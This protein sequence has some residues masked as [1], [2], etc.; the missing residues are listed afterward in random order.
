VILL[1]RH[2]WA[3]HR[4]DW[5]GDERPRPLDERGRRQ[6]AALVDLL[7]DYDVDRILSSPAARCVQT[8]EPLAAARGLDVEVREELFEDCQE[9]EGAAFVRGL[10][11]SPAISCHGGLS[12]SLV[13]EPQK[14]GEVIVLERRA[15]S[16]RSVTRLRPKG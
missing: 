16:L 7:A 14:K 5:E 9:E 13:G 3:G 1:I 6:A 15:G 8:V 12:W 2:A 4:T 10:D 11:G